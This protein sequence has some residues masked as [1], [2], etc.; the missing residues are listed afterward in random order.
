MRV[1]L[2]IM[3]CA[4]IGVVVLTKLVESRM[5]YKWTDVSRPQLSLTEER[6]TKELTD[7]V[8]DS[9]EPTVLLNG[10]LFG[11]PV[12]EDFDT[13]TSGLI[14]SLRSEYSVLVSDDA[15]AQW[16]IEH[17]WDICALDVILH[18]H[19]NRYLRSMGLDPKSVGE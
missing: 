17:A 5:S 7:S 15:K 16:L 18:H 19:R 6:Q 13:M 4:V 8:L 14:G 11:M 12:D 1:V 10:M 3:A 9:P 2:G